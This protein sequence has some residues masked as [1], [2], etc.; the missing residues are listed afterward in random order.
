MK[1]DCYNCKHLEWIDGD[2]G[3]PSGFT[4]HKRLTGAESE[5]YEWD[6]L[7]KLDSEEY[8]AKGKVCHES[9]GAMK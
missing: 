8:R 7:G 4:C 5:T 2:V 1:K 9:G 6:L 3:D